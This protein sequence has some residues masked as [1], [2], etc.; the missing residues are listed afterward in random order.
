MIRFLSCFILIITFS[1][2]LANTG[3]EE[4]NVQSEVEKEEFAFIG[5]HSHT[6][7]Y[8]IDVN[9]D[10]FIKDIEIASKIFKEK[11]PNSIKT[12]GIGSRGMP[13]RAR[14][15]KTAKKPKT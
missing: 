4:M 9:E 12:T 2:S 5:N 11:H 15:R 8:L 14:R 3:A 10:E 1:W 7:E 6:H 13:G